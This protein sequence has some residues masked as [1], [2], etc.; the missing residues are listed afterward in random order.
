MGLVTDGALL[1]D[2]K[3]RVT[4]RAAH[5]SQIRSGLP[6]RVRVDEA[7]RVGECRAPA[8]CE[9]VNEY[10][11]EPEKYAHVIVCRPPVLL[12]SSTLPEDAP[13]G[14]SDHY[15]QLDAEDGKNQI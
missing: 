6:V 9:F 7:G 14:S 12:G 3:D 8:S 11:K 5:A 4:N 15:I 10:V 13:E 1:R 2:I